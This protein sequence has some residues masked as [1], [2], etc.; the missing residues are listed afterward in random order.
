MRRLS[1]VLLLI[2]VLESLS[3]CGYYLAGGGPGL[4]KDRKIAVSMFANRTY[5]SSL[6]GKLRLALVNEL[7]GRGN[8]AETGGNDLVITGEI[9]S[10]AID[11]AA[12]S[13]ADKAVLYRVSMTVEMQLAEKGSGKVIWKSSETLRQEYPSAANLALQANARDAAL[14]SLCEKM[15]RTLVNR[16]SQA[17]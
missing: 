9:D 15:A 14:S 7:A 8:Y 17:F 12:F 10:L 13:S 11:T 5:Q 1:I 3:G 4:I 6:E 16:M 2:V